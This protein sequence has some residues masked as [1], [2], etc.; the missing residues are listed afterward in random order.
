MAQSQLQWKDLEGE[1]GLSETQV[2]NK[3]LPC[4]AHTRTSR[5]GRLRSQARQLRLVTT[6][7]STRNNLAVPYPVRYGRTD[8][9]QRWIERNNADECMRAY[10]RAFVETES[11]SSGS[12]RGRV[13]HSSL[14]LA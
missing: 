1:Q 9:R 2:S 14:G 6:P 13:A 8:E 3:L 12:H 4:F 5:Y 7:R 10:C 11:A